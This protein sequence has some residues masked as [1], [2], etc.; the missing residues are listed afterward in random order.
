[1]LYTCVERFDV[2]DTIEFFLKTNRAD[3]LHELGWVSTSSGLRRRT[4]Q[5]RTDAYRQLSF[6]PSFSSPFQRLTDVGLPPIPPL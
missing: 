5:G 1:M 3:L 2:T 4:V 6:L